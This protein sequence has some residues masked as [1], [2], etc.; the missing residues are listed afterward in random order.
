MICYTNT[1]LWLLICI[2][3]CETAVYNVKPDESFDSTVCDGCK[4]LSEYQGDK[5]TYFASNSDTHLYFKP[6]NYHITQS[7][8]IRDVHNISLI[9]SNPTN[10]I[11][12]CITLTP[13]EE[14]F[15]LMSGITKITLKN[16]LFLNCKAK[17]SG[18]PNKK[19]KFYVSLAIL[20]CFNIS[21]QQVT[22]NET[23]EKS[24]KL[25][26]VNVLGE[27]LVA[28][29]KSSGLE[30]IYLDLDKSAAK[31][32]NH[33]LTIYQYEAIFY[34]YYPHYQGVYTRN[35]NN[36][37][38]DYDNY[39]LHGLL[40]DDYTPTFEDSF[41]I[42]PENNTYNPNAI[43]KVKTVPAIT[44]IMLQSSHKINVK[45]TGCTFNML[46][47]HEVL[48]IISNNYRSHKCN[49][50]VE[51]CT[52]KNNVYWRLSKPIAS[53]VRIR[54]MIE[55]NK[56]QFIGNNIIEFNQCS[57]IQNFYKGSLIS[58]LWTFKNSLL[59]EITS[60]VKKQIII[61]NCFFT[62]NVFSRIFEFVSTK[63]VDVS[64]ILRH[65]RFENL[66]EKV[67]KSDF[68][69]GRPAI[70][71][72]NVSLS[73]ESVSFNA[74]NITKCLIHT[75]KKIMVVNILKFSNIKAKCLVS[76]L[77]YS[78]I[79][80]I[81]KVHIVIS[82]ISI[83]TSVFAVD[84]SYD[85]TLYSPCFFQYHYS[86]KNS[87]PIHNIV[88]TDNSNSTMLD[89]HT[90]N[91]NCKLNEDSSFYGSNPLI[92]HQQLFRF[93]NKTGI[94]K[95]SLFN[96]GLLCY[97]HDKL[98][99]NCFTNEL[100]LLYPGQSL[101]LYLT[102]NPSVTDNKAIPISVKI[103]FESITA[104]SIC[105]IS[106]L[107]QAEQLI[108][109]NCTLVNFTI[110]A[111]NEDMCKLI[112]Y[113]TKWYYPTI[114]YIKLQKCPFGFSYSKL[115][116]S[117]ICDEALVVSNI[118]KEHECNINDQT[119][120]RPAN[121]WISASTHNNSYTYH[122]SLHCP[123]HYCLPHSSHLNFSTPNSQC[124]FNRSGLLCGHCQ[125]GLS[126]VFS[127]SHCK[128]CSSIHLFLIVPIMVLGFLLVI[129]LFGLN[130]TVTNGA[131]NGFILYV[132]IISI[133]TP[134]LFP[135]VNHF[136][137]AY[138][139]ISLANLDLGIQTCFYNGMDDY[140][141]MW[142]QLAFPF[143]LIFIATLIIIT[144]R[145]STTIQRLTARR[146]LPVLATLFLL[147]YTKILRIVSSVLFFYSTITHL[148]SKHTT[149]VWSVDVNVSLF[150][151]RFTILF[152]VCLI[153]FLILLP[154]NGIL[155]FTRTLSRFNAINKFKPLLDAYQGPYKIK[156]YYW[157]GLQLLMR[158]IFFGTSSLDR[159]LNLTI[160]IVL[161]S[162]IE[163]MQ[164]A[165]KPFKEQF[166]NLQEQFF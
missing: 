23:D 116:K 98:K 82:N 134:I 108:R 100:G 153:L 27:S 58:I 85:N 44:L 115:M 94:Y 145:Y 3:N 52:F 118:I 91:I 39:D 63:N 47:Y 129:L 20:N 83:Q 7:F 14:I 143:Y 22:L 31:Y 132:N 135:D 112:L 161:F 45:I 17:L 32:Q 107:L 130:L 158:A 154:F 92:A 37:D 96:T 64:V 6:G 95:Y 5:E 152:V 157:T 111:D 8:I 110:L 36:D 46:Q 71:A 144:S 12:Y 79:N 24:G 165:V 77:K 114:Y 43:E 25:I 68:I 101:G 147:S 162:I 15:I 131:V 133:N 67:I 62:K 9:G 50:A 72:I 109:Q 163:V 48:T 34:E 86:A 28:N 103:Y 10:T 87:T 122:I 119:I 18:Y 76:G 160:G 42:R 156:F 121:S 19:F 105:K 57:F 53:L 136:T 33:I 41:F 1:L 142:L 70:Y 13:L 149:L 148:P 65:T 99:S 138:T 166:K 159:N 141:K 75:N 61:T 104:T 74:V 29:V 59:N 30:V 60:Q 88:I 11:I 151:V 126:T 81:S 120:L 155:L 89:F 66:I 128:A 150:G 124:Q 78:Y 113:S 21:I 40:F 123:F 35:S 106:S 84:Y 55:N 54:L 26:L 146:A 97:C 93:K 51:N 102:L 90:G 73:M 117:C 139:F 164:G 125:Q 69:I 2:T 137:P 140:A 80:L 38:Y 4:Y 16:L 127:S 49:I 56:T